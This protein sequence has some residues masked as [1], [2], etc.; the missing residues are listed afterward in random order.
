MSCGITIHLS[1]LPR[2]LN[3]GRAIRQAE[4]LRWLEINHEPDAPFLV[5][6]DHRD[7]YEAAWPPL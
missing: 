2:S 1:H 5:Q 3:K 7:S 4:I 6:D